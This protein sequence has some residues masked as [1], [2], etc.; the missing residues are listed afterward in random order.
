MRC[1]YRLKLLLL[2]VTLCVPHLHAA[3]WYHTWIT[4]LATTKLFAERR[5]VATLV[6][7]IPTGESLAENVD[8]SHWVQDVM[9]T[10]GLS[11]DARRLGRLLA[12]D[13][14]LNFLQ[15]FSLLS[16]KAIR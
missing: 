5:G 7:G 11:C 4:Q 8:V 16:S 1:V 3:P 2:P 6:P 14:L 12:V 13:N 9:A 10:Q 15:L